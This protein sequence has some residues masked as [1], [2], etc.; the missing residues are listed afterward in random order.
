MNGE[1]RTFAVALGG[2]DMQ[3]R[4]SEIEAVAAGLRETT[5][6]AVVAA[7]EALP[8]SDRAPAWELA[9]RHYARRKPLDEAAG[10]IGVDRLRARALMESFTAS[11]R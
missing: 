8:I 1:S 2:V 3:L 4:P 11:T 5:L 7:V 6:D 9:I 10:E